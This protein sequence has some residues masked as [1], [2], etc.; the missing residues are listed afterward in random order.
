M[1]LMDNIIYTLDSPAI[2]Y[3][4]NKDKRLAKVIS[5]LGN[6]EYQ[7]HTDHFSFL[8]HEIVEQMLSIKAGNVIFS[9]LLT[10]CEQDISPSRIM[11]L[12]PEQIKGC[13]MSQKKVQCIIDL[14]QAIN[15]STISFEKLSDLPDKE[16]IQILTQI[17]GI[18]SWTSKM[19]LIFALNRLDV[20]PFEDGAFLQSYRWLY[21]TVETTPEIIKKKCNKWK[22][23]S[24][25]AARYMYRALDS[26][27]TKETFHLYK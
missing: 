3:L 5:L 14:A 20:L 10:L 16:V 18:G 15:S 8:V 11:T 19:Y 27:L 24:S 25:L 23:Y 6:L 7:V 26:G 17:R 1:I 2:L 13:G 22:P 9:R 12:T 4:R 21:N